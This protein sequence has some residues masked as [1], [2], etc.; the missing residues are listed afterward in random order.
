MSMRAHLH[1]E[2]GSEW[3]AGGDTFNDITLDRR[4]K[5]GGLE[6]TTSGIH[7]PAGWMAGLEQTKQCGSDC[8]Y[9]DML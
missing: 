3:C 5:E 6:T 7:W 4:G 8:M 1:G 2:F 9:V